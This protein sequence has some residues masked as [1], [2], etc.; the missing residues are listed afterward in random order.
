L[1]DAILDEGTI[2]GYDKLVS[3][4]NISASIT[5]RVR[6]YLDSNCSQC[7]RPGGVQALWD[8]RYDTPLASQNIINGAVNDT[9]GITGAK[10]VVP[11][12]LS[13]SIMYLRVNSVDPIIK[14]PPL[15][16]NRIDASAV[17][18]LAQWIVPPAN[19][20]PT[21]PAI[22]NRTIL[23]GATLLITNAATDAEAPPQVLT[24]S[25]T[26]PPPPP[27][28]A[29]INS[30][31]GLFSW[32]PAIAQAGTINLLNIQVS[33]SGTPSLCATQTFS[34]TVAR[35]ARPGLAGASYLNGQFSLLVS[36]DAGPDYTVQASTN[37][38]N[39]DSLLTTNSPVLPFL[40]ADPGTANYRQRFYR[41]LL[42]P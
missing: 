36:G 31:N 21:L 16:R 25:L 12:D 15:A 23:A 1:F 34:V 11:Q 7:H 10:V 4:T 3:L 14:M 35:P 6:S 2:A 5:N 18:A 22:P 30:S 20:P 41:V 40:F 37:L 32:R 9:L 17:A 8:A 38:V 29:A 28:G 26:G 24:Y 13:K 33:D 39:W 19:T 42:G 27:A